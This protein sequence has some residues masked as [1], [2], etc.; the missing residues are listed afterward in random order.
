MLEEQWLVDMWGKPFSFGAY[1]CLCLEIPI[2]LKVRGCKFGRRAASISSNV[3]RQKTL[4]NHAKGVRMFV[5]CCNSVVFLWYWLWTKLF[6][7]FSSESI[8][9][10]CK[11]A[12]LK[13]WSVYFSLF[14]G[15]RRM[16]FARIF[17]RL[18]LIPS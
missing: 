12:T 6:S 4:K 15:V 17:F 3:L 14:Y 7:L 10:C 9:I 13:T 1:N 16:L 2:A 5:C 11:P 8:G 18:I